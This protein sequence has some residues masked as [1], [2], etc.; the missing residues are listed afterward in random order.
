MSFTSAGGKRQTQE[1]TS[2]STSAAP[3]IEPPRPAPVFVRERII[4]NLEIVMKLLFASLAAAALFAAAP[5]FAA[6]E[7]P[8]FETGPVWDFS[9]V[10]TKDGHFDD[11]MAWLD[12]GWKAQ[13]EALK[14][15]GVIID[16]K[17]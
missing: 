11:Y 13:E 6:D 3:D 15:A 17:V 8:A 12:T 4:Q 1:T 14:K 16:Y 7:G 2:R 10:Q 5:A 9:Q